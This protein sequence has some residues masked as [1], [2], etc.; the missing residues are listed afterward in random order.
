MYL[1]RIAVFDEEKSITHR[2][3]RPIEEPVIVKQGTPVDLFDGKTLDG[4]FATPRVYVPRG[5]AFARM[6]AD[7]LYDA[8]IEH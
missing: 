8:V 7:Q 1:D 2:R 5:E 6:P 3:A 4:W